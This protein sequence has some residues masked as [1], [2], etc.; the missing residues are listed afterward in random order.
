[1]AQKPPIKG[2]YYLYRDKVYKVLLVSSGTDE[3]ILEDISDK[4]KFSVRYGVFIHSYKRVFRV[5]EIASWLNRTSRSI[6]RYEVRGQI[7]RAKLYPYGTRNIRF[8]TIEDVLEIH[9]MISGLHR[10]RPRKD[11]RIINNTLP[12]I[13]RLKIDLRE[14]FG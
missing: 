14:R 1:M 2:E 9:Q 13:G 10:G 11:G 4:K 6:Y 5:G 3:V 7:K 8:Y 12:D